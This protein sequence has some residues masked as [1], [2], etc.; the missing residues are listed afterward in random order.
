[1]TGV[2]MRHADKFHIRFILREQIFFV[3][4]CHFL[5]HRPSGSVGEFYSFLHSVVVSLLVSI[6]SVS[7]LAL[8]GSGGLWY[9]GRRMTDL[10]DRGRLFVMGDL[11]GCPRALGDAEVE[12]L[13]GAALVVLGDFGLLSIDGTLPESFR[14]FDEQ[15]AAVGCRGLVLRGNHDLAGCFRRESPEARR[16]WSRFVALEPLEDLEM[17]LWGGRR[18]LVFPGAHSV[19]KEAR[20]STGRFWCAEEVMPDAEDSRVRSADFV[21]AH[22]GMGLPPR[23]MGPA[24]TAFWRSCQCADPGLSGRLLEERRKVLRVVQRSGARLW[25]CGHYH[26]SFMDDFG[27]FRVVALDE[28]ELLEVGPMLPDPVV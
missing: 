13:R 28:Q 26:C 16:F 1:M 25:F 17:V 4:A 21:L 22:A 11:H 9:D 15:L 20:L 8:R 7:A 19:D 12:A 3:A 24:Q 5:T 10:S 23:M 2:C 14:R 27:D 18:A 6:R